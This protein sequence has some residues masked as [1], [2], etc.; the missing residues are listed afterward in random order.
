LGAATRE[1]EVGGTPLVRLRPAGLSRAGRAVKRAYDVAV[2]GAVLAVSAPLFGALALAVKASGPGPV[3]FRQA[4]V[5]EGG[6]IIFTL[7]FRTMAQNDDSDVTWSVAGDAR[8]GKV[9]RFLRRTSLDELPQLLNV[10][11]GDMSLVGPRPERPY[12]VDQFSATVPGYADRH[13]MPVGLTGWAQ[14]HHLRGNTSIEDRARFDNYYIEN[15]SPWLDLRV[16]LRT[17]GA[18]WG[19][20]QGFPEAPRAGEASPAKASPAPAAH[21]ERH[22]QPGVPG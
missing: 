1:S 18:I 20:A 11:R 15:W 22:A 10:V 2:A 9:G 8:V 14:V 12:W 5:G 3:F 21:P 6:R 7:K 16:V 19:H 13:R 4:R 17:L